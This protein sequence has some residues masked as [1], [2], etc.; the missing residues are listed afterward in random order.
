MT[1]TYGAQGETKGIRRTEDNQ[2]LRDNPDSS[3]DARPIGQGIGTQC[4]E[5]DREDRSTGDRF[6]NPI[7]GIL[8]QLIEDARKQLVKSKECIVWYQ[9]EARE[10]EE[11][12]RK[13]EHLK[14]LHEQQ[15]KEEKG[16][17]A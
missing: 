2:E 1:E 9:S 7:G 15:V 6:A 3:K 16:E 17:T 4:L 13:L 14:E 10:F 11:K 5:L 12:L 8:D